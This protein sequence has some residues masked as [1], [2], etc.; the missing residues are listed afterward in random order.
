MNDRG[1]SLKHK[2]A[3]EL[4]AANYERLARVEDYRAQVASLSLNFF[5]FLLPL[6]PYTPSRTYTR[7]FLRMTISRRDSPIEDY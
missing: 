7:Q 6:T 1:N 5:Y 2:Q 3:R 4:A